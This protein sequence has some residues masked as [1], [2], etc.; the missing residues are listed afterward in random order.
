MPRVRVSLSLDPTHVRDVDAYVAAHHGTDRSKVVDE[1]IALWSA[2]QQQ[3]A[4]A[5]QFADADDSG[6]AELDAW[7][8]MRRAATTRRLQRS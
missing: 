2:S 3:A 7:R 8:Q 1:A 4:M 6:A 5:L